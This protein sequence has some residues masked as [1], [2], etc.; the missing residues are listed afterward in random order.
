MIDEQLQDFIT[1]LAGETVSSL[2]QK[3]YVNFSLIVLPRLQSAGRGK[4]M[5]AELLARC[6]TLVGDLYEINGAPNR[7]ETAYKKALVFNPLRLDTLKRIIKVQIDTGKFHEAFKNVNIALDNDPDN[8]PLFTE[9]QRIQDD[10]NYESEPCFSPD[11]LLWG[12]NEALANDK[13]E[14]VIQTV[15][16]TNMSDVEQLRCL[17]RA[18][19]AVG[20][21]ANYHKVWQTIRTLDQSAVPNTV[22]LYYCPIS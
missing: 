12:L 22:D 20:H 16:G 8:M 3:G 6:W 5:D 15:L 7:A 10:M 18:Y 17:A 1:Q 2:H 19:G 4:L 13:F 14:S 11:D 21:H 9:R